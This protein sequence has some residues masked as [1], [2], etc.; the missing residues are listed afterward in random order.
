MEAR[1]GQYPRFRGGRSSRPWE[2]YR[3]WN[4]AM[5]IGWM[6]EEELAEAIPWFYTLYLAGQVLRYLKTSGPVKTRSK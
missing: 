1:P 6:T 2:A 5:A 3:Y 4:A